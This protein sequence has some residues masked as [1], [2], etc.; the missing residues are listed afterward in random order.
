M[1]LFRKP[2]AD[3]AIGESFQTTVTAEDWA[4][5][6]QWQARLCALA[7]SL[8]RSHP[9]IGRPLV[10]KDWASSGGDRGYYHD[11]GALVAAFDLGNP[12]PGPTVVTFTR[13][14]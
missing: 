12:F 11:G 5:G 8:R 4:T 7:V 3:I 9:D 1:L 10:Y 13:E 6:S 2:A 14:R